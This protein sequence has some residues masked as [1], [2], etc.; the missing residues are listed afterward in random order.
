MS[1]RYE[2]RCVFIWGWSKATTRVLNELGADGW[3]LVAV[4][5]CW[6]YLERP[7]R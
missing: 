6:H 7:V 4:S 1:D 3:R 2:Y 5:W